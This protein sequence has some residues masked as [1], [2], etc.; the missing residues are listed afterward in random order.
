MFHVLT[1]VSLD[2]VRECLIIQFVCIIYCDVLLTVS[3][4]SFSINR[5]LLQSEELVDFIHVKVF[6][7]EDFTS[8]AKFTVSLD[9]ID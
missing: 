6:L 3:F 2:P 7:D 9:F 8:T 4:V 5:S 1:I